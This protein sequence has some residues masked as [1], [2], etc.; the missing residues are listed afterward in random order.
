MKRFTVQR[1][2][3][4]NTHK[5]ITVFSTV[6]HY[7]VF[8]DEQAPDKVNKMEIRRLLNTRKSDYAVNVNEKIEGFIM[9]SWNRE[10]IY[11]S[12]ADQAEE[13]MFHTE[14]NEEMKKIYLN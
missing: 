9:D 10:T 11:F 13:F 8:F 4:Q 1:E 12:S 14:G 5:S 2:G 7:L 3:Q 6:D